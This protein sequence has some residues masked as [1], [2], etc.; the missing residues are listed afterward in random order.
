MAHVRTWRVRA[1]RVAWMVVAAQGAAVALTLWYGLAEP[2]GDTPWWQL[3]LWDGSVLPLV[4]ALSAVVALAPD[5]PTDEW[6]GPA[7]VLLLVAALA[8]L[9]VSLG[10]PAGRRPMVAGVTIVGV[11]LLA[12]AVG[13]WRRGGAPSPAGA[14]VLGG[15]VLAGV[16]LTTAA[17]GP[18]V[19]LDLVE[20]AAATVTGAGGRWMVTNLGLSEMEDRDGSS[21][22]VTVQLERGGRRVLL[23]P[24]LHERVSAR[25]NVEA[26]PRSATWRGLRADVR[27][28]L[29]QARPSRTAEAGRAQLAL[30]VAPWA[31]V[32]WLGF[33]L[34]VVGAAASALHREDA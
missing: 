8:A 20:G 32:A 31:A 21:I 12:A 14:L 33:G 34:L 5:A 24:E 7:V 9:A 13:R 30:A 17:R 6:A 29:R 4:A 3:P 19:E 18:R 10:V 28:T 27:A 25:G 16:G 26:I 15:L 11:A 22:A 1:R 23:T 2:V